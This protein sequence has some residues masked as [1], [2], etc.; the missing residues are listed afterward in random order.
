[1]SFQSQALSTSDAQHF[2]S[3]GWFD[4]SGQRKTHIENEGTSHDVAE[5]KATE[6][7]ILEHPAMF[8]ITNDLFLICHDVYER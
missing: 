8:M 6:N 2:E 3:L 5:K 1:M 7:G 4:R